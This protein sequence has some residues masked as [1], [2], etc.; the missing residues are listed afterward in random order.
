MDDVAWALVPTR[1]VAR[2]RNIAA[3]PTSEEQPRAFSVNGRQYCPNLRI[4]YQANG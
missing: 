1:T 2:W 3:R 4:K